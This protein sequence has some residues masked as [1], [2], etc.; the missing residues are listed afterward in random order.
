MDAVS[1]VVQRHVSKLAGEIGARPVGSRG[2]QTAVDYAAAQFA[3][4]GLTVDRQE[5]ECL[6]W[7][8]SG[9][10]LF[11]DGQRLPAFANPYSPPCDVIARTVVAGSL[12][13]LQDSELAGRIAVLHGALTR[14]PLFPKRF[15]YFAVEEHQAIITALESKQ[16]VAIIALREGFEPAPY[17]EDGDLHLPSVTVAA[18]VGE[19]LLVSDSPITLRVRTAIQPSRGANVVA[20]STGEGKRVVLSAHIDTKH[21]TPGAVDDAAGVAALLAT[22][23]ELS[24]RQLPMPIEYVL[25]NGEDHYSQ[26]GELAYMQH[27]LNDDIA[28]AINVDG[29]GWRDSRTMVGLMLQ[30]SPWETTIREVL[31][32]H[33]GIVESE[34]WPEGDHMLF[35]MRGLPALVLATDRVHALIGTVVHTERD[36]VDGVSATVVADVVEF[37]T[38]ILGSL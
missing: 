31:A 21:G 8:D 22:A 12:A 14:E 28:L 6:D 16:P 15:P 3:A 27:S 29:V 4:L 10:D 33:L 38:D 11:L 5:F 1:T 26:A 19:R 20:R 23:G 34:P 2:N 35:A 32:R 7:Q 30:A 9:A 18:S 24:A 25:F 36:T 17:L 37:I 13:E